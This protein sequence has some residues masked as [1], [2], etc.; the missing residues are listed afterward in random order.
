VSQ[1]VKIVIIQLT[2]FYSFRLGEES[3]SAGKTR[4]EER[5]GKHNAKSE[6]KK[7]K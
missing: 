2:S 7:G 6:H 3:K 1:L 5:K 4:K